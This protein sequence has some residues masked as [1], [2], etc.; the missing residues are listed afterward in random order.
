[1]CPRS[2]ANP[3]SSRRRKIMRSQ[4]RTLEAGSGTVV[5]LG[6]IAAMVSLFGLLQAPLSNIYLAT[7][8]QTVADQAAI[9]AAD[10]LRGLASGIPCSVAGVV[11]AENGGNLTTCRIVEN[12]VYVGVR[13]NPFIVAE[14]LAGE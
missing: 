12:T 13:M 4:T 11:V 1:M 2:S 9:A 14:A 5:A 10:S 8:A 7:K 3:A 6:L